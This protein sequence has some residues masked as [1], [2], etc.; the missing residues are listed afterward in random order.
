[1]IYQLLSMV[2]NKAEEK[3]DLRSVP[4]GIMAY[5]GDGIYE[6]IV[7]NFLIKQKIWNQNQIH[8]K[9]IQFVNAKAQAALLRKLEPVLTDEEQTILRRGRNSNAG[10]VPKN[11]NMLDYR[12][13]TA[14]EAVLGY[15]MFK[16]DLERLSVIISFIENYIKNQISGEST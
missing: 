11:A 9:A 12:Y 6:L 10:N 2:Q 3:I 16:G 13:S 14:F 8:R 15:L 7:R 5:M 1:M 4:P